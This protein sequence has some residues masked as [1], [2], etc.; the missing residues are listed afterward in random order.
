LA[1]G[2]IISNLTR[3]V[4]SEVGLSRCDSSQTIRVV[5]LNNEDLD[6]LYLGIRWRRLL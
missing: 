6:Y 3:E 1:L 2:T 4:H 5:H